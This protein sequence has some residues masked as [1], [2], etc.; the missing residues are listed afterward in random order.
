MNCAPVHHLPPIKEPRLPPHAVM[1]SNVLD[2][3]LQAGPMARFVL[4]VLLFF[5]VVCWALIVEKWWEFRAIKRD[6]KGFSRVFRQGGRFSLIYGAAKKF[7]ASP[8][9]QVYS[10][11]GLELASVYGGVEQVDAT[12]EEGEGLPREAIDS[13]HRAMLRS[14]EIE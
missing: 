1:P 8:L 3:I 7:R 11:A 12:L 10:A 9:A 5:S 13:A 14:T 4:G 6:S 2:P